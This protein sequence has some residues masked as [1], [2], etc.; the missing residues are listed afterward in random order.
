MLDGTGAAG[1]LT[2]D[3]ISPNAGVHKSIFR[4]GS[5][6]LCQGEPVSW[7]SR[8]LKKR[9]RRKGWSLS[10][11]SW[12]MGKEDDDGDKSAFAVH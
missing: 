9:L 12:S 10:S 5:C 11:G 7:A 3:L 8:E 1:T 4:C 6:W 2:C